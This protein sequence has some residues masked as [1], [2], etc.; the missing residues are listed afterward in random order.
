MAPCK[1]NAGSQGTIVFIDESGFSEGPVIRRT[2]APR[3]R[4][5]VLRPRFRHWRRMSAVGALT[6]RLDGK[7]ARVFLSLLTPPN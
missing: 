1:K 5:P 3:G 6:Y 2:W 4:T 7:R